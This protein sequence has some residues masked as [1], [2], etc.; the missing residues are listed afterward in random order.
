V[1]ITVISLHSLATR[2]NDDPIAIWKKAGCYT[3]GELEKV[4]LLYCDFDYV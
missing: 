3:I 2:R 4:A 1:A